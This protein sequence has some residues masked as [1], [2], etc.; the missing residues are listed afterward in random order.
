[1]AIQPV[2]LTCRTISLAKSPHLRDGRIDPRASGTTSVTSVTPANLLV[3]RRCPPALIHR[4][5]R[6]SRLTSRDGDRDWSGD[7]ELPSR[8]SRKAY[9]GHIRQPGEGM[10]DVAYG[11]G[12]RMFQQ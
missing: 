8:C 2:A 12:L 3:R 1:M 7:S 5:T 6:N 4:V 11:P 10:P 9:R